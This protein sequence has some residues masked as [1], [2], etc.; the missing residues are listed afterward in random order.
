MKTTL[1][2]SQLIDMFSFENEQ[3]RQE[4]GHYLDLKGD[5]YYINMIN[6]LE[7]NNIKIRGNEGKI[8]Y[9]TVAD[10]Y[11]YD[12]RIRKIVY[13]YIGALEEYFRAYILNNNIDFIATLKKNKT[14]YDELLKSIKEFENKNSAEQL[15]DFSFRDTINVIIDNQSEIKLFSNINEEYLKDNLNAV[16][17]LRNKV[18][19]FKQI[20][21][22]NDY[23]SCYG[24]FDDKADLKNNIINLIKLLPRCFR[25]KAV[26]E[27]KKAKDDLPSKDTLNS[28]ILNISEQDIYGDNMVRIGIVGYG[29]L[30]KSCEEIA[31]NDKRFDL[32][33]IF[34]RRDPEEMRSVFGTEF[35]SQDKIQEFKDKID[36]LVLCVGSANDLRDLASKVGKDFCTVDSFDNHAEMKEHFETINKIATDNNKVALIGIGWDP[37]IF[38]I[39][40]GLFDG[41]TPHDTIHTFWGE[42]VSQG[43]SEAIRKIEGV[44]YAI[45]YTVPKSNIVNKIKD[46]KKV[47]LDSKQK[48]IRE[49]YVVC[50]KK[51]EKRIEKEIKN[52]PNYFVG[53]ETIVNF[54]TEEEFLEKH[55]EMPHGGLVIKNAEVCG[56][57][58]QMEF[59]LKLENNPKYTASVLMSYAIA[60]YKFQKIHHYGAKTILDVPI[61]FLLGD[62]YI[63]YI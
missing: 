8:N 50:D 6:F 59:A 53:Y 41:V 62:D 21:M 27:L 38:S 19:H 48:H 45:Q 32:V 29:N 16:V 35:Y 33:G 5:M 13:K 47:E 44:K 28:I 54:I 63:S 26:Q 7:S 37:G 52:I 3:R 40:R 22:C 57:K 61:S 20:L 18:N 58:E 24:C 31:H 39:M 42:G 49:C 17:N 43:H 36:V 15:L 23:K 1:N 55:Q 46:G 56:K 9:R 10:F 25:K 60:N 4:A 30:G 2:K 12:K 14:R 11:R 34:T 51:D